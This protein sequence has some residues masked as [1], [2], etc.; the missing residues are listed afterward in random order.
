MTRCDMQ[1]VLVGLVIVLVG[2]GLG[3]GQIA[4]DG[5]YWSYD[6][7]PVLLLGG[8]NHGHNPFIDHDTDNDKDNQG[9]STPEQIEQALN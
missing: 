3:W 5:R 8:W 7:K 6:G 1:W 2:S 9:V 4:V